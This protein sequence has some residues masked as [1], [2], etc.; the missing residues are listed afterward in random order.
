[1]T[2]DEELSF[3][4]GSTDPRD[5]G[6]AGY[7]PGVPRL[8][9]PELRSTDGPAGVRLRGTATAMPA[10]VALAATF[11]PSLAFSYGAFLELFGSCE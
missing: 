3:V 8:G 2:L 11:D 1:M 7:I 4:H 9:I 10:P 6:A 5:L